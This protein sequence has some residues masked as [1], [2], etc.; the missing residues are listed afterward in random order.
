MKKYSPAQWAALPPETIAALAATTR[1]Q[2]LSE[3]EKEAGL[4]RS[5]LDLGW[6][7]YSCFQTSLSYPGTPSDVSFPLHKC[8]PVA[9][10]NF[11]FALFLTVTVIALVVLIRLS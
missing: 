9:Y 6:T 1:Y 3:A 7:C 4:W 5:T 2:P 11:W 10:T 8:G